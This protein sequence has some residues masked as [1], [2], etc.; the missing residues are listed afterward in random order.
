[1]QSLGGRWPTHY[2]PTGNRWSWPPSPLKATVIVSNGIFGMP[3]SLQSI[4]V[5]KMVNWSSF[6]WEWWW[7]WQQQQQ[8]RGKE[9]KNLLVRIQSMNRVPFP[10]L[11]PPPLFFFRLPLLKRCINIHTKFKSPFLWWMAYFLYFFPTLLFFYINNISYQ[12]P[13]SGI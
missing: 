5:T 4:T 12:S 11:I 1:M 7:R 6:L 13:H 3:P 2:P 8:I 9:L 10:L